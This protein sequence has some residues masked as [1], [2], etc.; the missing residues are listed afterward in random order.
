MNTPEKLATDPGY[1]TLLESRLMDEWTPVA[2]KGFLELYSATL[3]W[4]DNERVWLA[5]YN[6]DE[7]SEADLFLT[8]AEVDWL[9]RE[10]TSLK[11]RQQALGKEWT[12]LPSGETK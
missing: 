2:R 9:I 1:E 11:A 5:L 4:P 3:N 10:L 6:H 8:P 7:E 12:Q